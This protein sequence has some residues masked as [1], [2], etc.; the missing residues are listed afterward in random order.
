M[1]CILKRSVDIVYETHFSDRLD[2]EE[3]LYMRG[4]QSHEVVGVLIYTVSGSQK[5]L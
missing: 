4:R 2:E 5:K 1:V 3:A